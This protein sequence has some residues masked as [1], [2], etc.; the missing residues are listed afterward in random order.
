MFKLTPRT[1]VEVFFLYEKVVG[2]CAR[3]LRLE[4]PLKGCACMIGLVGLG[5]F[6][7][8]IFILEAT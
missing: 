3:C 6:K 7:T 2:N 4:H 1:E 8:N 5:R